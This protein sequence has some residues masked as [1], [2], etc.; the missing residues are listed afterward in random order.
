MCVSA[1][2]SS[3][4]NFSFKDVPVGESI[5][6]KKELKK[7]NFRRTLPKL[8]QSTED[9]RKSEH[10]KVFSMTPSTKPKQKSTFPILNK[11][12]VN[13]TE[14]KNINKD[15]DHLKIPLDFKK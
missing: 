2:Q 12:K 7:R 3:I 5:E 8:Q 6:I 9:Q 1:R 10:P 14:K 4:E 13:K 15:I 11:P